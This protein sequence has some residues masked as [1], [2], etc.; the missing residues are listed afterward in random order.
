MPPSL[1]LERIL[2]R[3][4]A[5]VASRRGAV[6]VAALEARAEQH[7]PRGVAAARRREGGGACPRRA[8]AVA[9]PVAAVVVIR[10]H[11]RRPGAACVDPRRHPL[12]LAGCLAIARREL[13]AETIELVQRRAVEAFCA[14]VA[15][16]PTSSPSDTAPGQTGD[17]PSATAPGQTGEGPGS[18]APG[19]SEENPGVTAPGQTDDTTPA[20][21]AAPPGK[22]E[23]R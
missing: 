17:S 8:A 6:P 3:T 19:Q 23:S 13:P 14:D 16:P 18:T 5:D 22:R 9:G 12:D 21:A 2:E 20:P 1:Y 7:A 10:Q 4:R 11:P 15:N